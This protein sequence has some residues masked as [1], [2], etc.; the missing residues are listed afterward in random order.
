MLVLKFLSFVYKKLLKANQ[1]FFL[2]LTYKPYYFD[3]KTFDS[4]I[5]VEDAQ[6]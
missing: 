1:T 4:H 2:M 6:L 3:D 5:Y